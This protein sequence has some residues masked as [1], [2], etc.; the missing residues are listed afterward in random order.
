MTEAWAAIIAAI[1]GGVLGIGG[2]L[3]GVV[4]SRRQTVDQATV[5][6]GQWLRGQ[7]Q[8]AYTETLAAW[9]TFLGEAQQFWQRYEF[10]LPEGS[11]PHE[12]SRHR[13]NLLR[14]P[15]DRVEKALDATILLSRQDVVDV[16]E[17]LRSAMTRVIAA[18]P[19][20]TAPSSTGM[21]SPEQ[22]RVWEDALNAAQQSR[23]AFYRKARHTQRT[24]PTVGTKGGML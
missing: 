21:S 5:E 22:E 14:G 19:T 10:G 12:A 9:D 13:N 18:L 8:T 3:A 11:I 6:H 7:R 1:A 23:D 20:P 24:P 17:Q 15:G 16:A 4:T 2:T